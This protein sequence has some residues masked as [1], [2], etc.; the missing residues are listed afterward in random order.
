V[1]M[2]EASGRGAHVEVE[3]QRAEIPGGQVGKEACGSVEQGNRVVM[4]GGGQVYGQGQ[5]SLIGRA[6]GSQSMGQGSHEVKRR[7]LMEGEGNAKQTGAN[8]FVGGGE[9]RI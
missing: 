4:G 7:G 8:G 3:K 6:Y 1:G 2:G 5:G 9:G